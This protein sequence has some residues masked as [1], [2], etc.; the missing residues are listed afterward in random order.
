MERKISLEEFQLMTASDDG[1][2]DQR[3][4]AVQTFNDV[5]ISGYEVISGDE[6]TV[7]MHELQA[8]EEVKI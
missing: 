3:P 8:R 4:E 2:L 1:M 6:M 7:E 5:F